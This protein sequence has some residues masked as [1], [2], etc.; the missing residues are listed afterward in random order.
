MALKV[1]FNSLWVYCVDYTSICFKLNVLEP[2]FKAIKEKNNCPYTQRQ[3]SK[4][5][6]GDVWNFNLL[7]T[8][9]LS[10]LKTRFSWIFMKIF[11]SKVHRRVGRQWHWSR[12]NKTVTRWIF[13]LRIKQC[14]FHE[15]F[16]RQIL[17]SWQPCQRNLFFKLLRP[18]IRLLSSVR[19]KLS[20]KLIYLFRTK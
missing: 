11:T 3:M 18:K 10:M 20:R 17:Q 9:T 12:V 2:E 8:K 14:S 19:K 13:V 7:H 6:A 5:V 15:R 16:K 1:K 4:S